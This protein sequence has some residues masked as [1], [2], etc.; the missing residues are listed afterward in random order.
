[1]KKVIPLIWILLIPFMVSACLKNLPGEKREPAPN[2]PVVEQGVTE[3]TG[4]SLT[5]SAGTSGTSQNQINQ[6]NVLVGSNTL[7]AGVTYD[8][9]WDYCKAVGT[10]NTPGS[11]YTGKTPNDEVTRSI[12]Q[13]MG[14]NLTEVPNHITI[15]RCANGQV[16]GCDSSSYPQC[17][18]LVDFSTQPSEIIKTECAKPEMENVTLPGAV[19]GHTTAFEWT[20]ISGLPQITGQGVTADEFGF[21]ANIWYPVIK[22]P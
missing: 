5:D 22:Q 7:P 20:C 8:N 10:I 11:E 14:I 21:N 3:Q 17:P 4:P 19:T 16:W 18:E 9:P 12:L 13:A 1:M 6:V 15:W 2:T